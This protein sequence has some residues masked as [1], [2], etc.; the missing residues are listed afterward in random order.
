MLTYSVVM[1]CAVLG[2]LR[3]EHDAPFAGAQSFVRL[4]YM[5]I[6]R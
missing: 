6:M 1:I 4:G 3:V 2:A 5:R